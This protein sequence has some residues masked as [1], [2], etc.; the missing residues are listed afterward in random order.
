MKTR[1]F[2]AYLLHFPGPLHISNMRDDYGV[3]LQTI[4]SD[5][6]YAAI[7]ATLAI[8]G[9]DIPTNG[10]LGCI[11]SSLFPYYQTEESAEPTLFFP[12]PMSF[13][14]K[15]D[16]TNNIKILKKV[17]WIDKHYLELVLNGNISKE[18]N[19]VSNVHDAYLTKSSIEKFIY[20]QVKNR[21]TISRSGE[22]AKPFYM[23]DIYFKGHSGLF[24][25][26]EGDTSIIDKTLPLLSHEGLGTDRNVGH[27]Y[28]E[29]TKTTIQL[30]VPEAAD[31]GVVL[32]TYIPENKE[33]LAKNVDSSSA[34]YELIR[35][36]GWITAASYNTLRKNAIYAFAAGSVLGGVSSG[37]GKLVD[38]A[39]KNLVKHPIWR[40]GK[41]IVLPIK[42]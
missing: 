6:M 41:T 12:K 32:S 21:V 34:A 7:T 25:L 18:E 28:F 20:S 42:M 5:T 8:M 11:I 2:V 14:L 17:A 27:G 35:R 10:D 22:D 39:P 3:S 13:T 37:E 23:D 38:L 29:F 33:Q 15:D 1:Q 31:L 19:V 36:G 16:D 26:V 9:E 40:C 30:Q 24:F 4:S